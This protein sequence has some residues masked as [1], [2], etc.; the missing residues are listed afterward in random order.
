MAPKDYCLLALT[1]EACADPMS[2]FGVVDP[3]SPI[4]TN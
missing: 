3:P 1:G 4:S 2:S